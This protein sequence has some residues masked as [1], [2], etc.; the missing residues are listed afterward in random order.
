MANQQTI[1]IVLKATDN[2]SK[3]LKKFEAQA[4]A[5]SKRIDRL[6]ATV[7]LDVVANTAAAAAKVEKFKASV[8]G[9]EATISVDAN[10]SPAERA[11]LRLRKEIDRTAGSGNNLGAILGVV[12]WPAIISGA[13]LAAQ[14]VAALGAASVALTS[15][16][17][18]A[19]GV[20]AALPG[21][22]AAV[23]QG[24]GV[25][26]LAFSDG[27]IG[28]THEADR[29]KTQ[30]DAFQPVL[31]GLQQTAQRG[32]LP[33]VSDAFDRLLTLLPIA[34]TAIGATGSAMGDLARRAADLVTSGPFAADF[35]T[36]A[37]NNV[38]LI[39]RAGDGALSLANALRN[40]LVVGQP[41]LAWLVDLGARGAAW[42]DVATTAGRESGRL[43]GFL[44]RTQA[45]LTTLG[46]SV[47]DFTTGLFNIGGAANEM[48][49]KFLAAIERAAARFREWTGSVEGQNSLRD[50]FQRAEP[51]IAEVTRLIGDVAR[52]FGGLAGNSDLAPLIAQIREQFLPM[53]VKLA[54]T[55]T[56]SLGPALVNMAT[57]FGNLFTIMGTESGT[58]VG[59]INNFAALAG[60]LARFL[61]EH[62]RLA[63]II[64]QFAVLST[65]LKY[66]PFA[67]T[68]ASML[69]FGIAN[70]STGASVVAWFA[71]M[72]ASA[73][74]GIA[75]VA[76]SM[77]RGVAAGASAT[78]SLIAQAASA[79]ASMVASAARQVAAWALLAAQSMIH[80]VRTA[81]AFVVA[82]GPV[83][84]V[85]A[86]VVALAALIIA[87]WDKISAATK[88]IWE[89]TFAW[90][91]GV[92]QRINAAVSSAV[93]GV[94][95][96]VEFVM[97]VIKAVWQNAWQNVLDAYNNIKARIA[98]GVDS[99]F[100]GLQGAFTRGVEAIKS[101][102]ERIKEIAASPVRFIVD[103]VYNN[104]IRKFW[105]TAADVLSLSKLPEVRLGFASGGR[106][107]GG[108]DRTGRDDVLARLTRG[109]WVMPTAAVEKYGPG[110]M[111]AIQNRR[112]DGYAVGG[113][114]GGL[115]SGLMSRL[116]AWSAA[117]GSNMS[118]TSGL[119]TRSEQVVLYNR[120]LSGNGPVAARPGTSRHESG[121]A[122]DLA[123]IFRRGYSAG[124]RAAEFG[125]RYTVP[126][127]NW[128]VEA[129]GGAQTGGAA[130]AANNG[131]GGIMGWFRDRIAGWVSTI[132]E[133]V[134]RLVQ[135]YMLEGGAM[136]QLVGGA[137]L[138]ALEGAANVV[139][140]RGD[141]R[142]NGMA[143]GG[144]VKHRRGGTSVR[145]G[146]G[147]YDEAVVPLTGRGGSSGELERLV[148]LMAEQ[149][150]ELKRVRRATEEKQVLAVSGRAIGQTADRRLGAMGRRS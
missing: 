1:D 58:L 63:A 73:A 100:S 118:V 88:R 120:Y 30:I 124:A 129:Q 33:G 122:A 47:R 28:A 78:A 68:I 2:A 39:S 127:E 97:N 8:D 51:V 87:N 136:R 114:V 31:K 40:V 77:A 67:G 85:I 24:A 92:W 149:N 108:T 57:Q 50:F 113:D 59:V 130:V 94:R 115:N 49:N 89:A 126:S 4:A 56:G 16:V 146:E 60:V 137:G 132:L 46:H 112:F 37:T 26:A 148:A 3:V 44:Q 69:K 125:L 145:L 27:W 101:T 20:L 105:N 11:L 84:W 134:K 9:D 7:N 82:M 14:G 139:R 117:V 17:A 135:N 144:V 104:G 119:R 48:G 107:P 18:P 93:D 22:Y 62:P 128:H 43:A 41:L 70:A 23:G 21:L 45:V 79:A 103:S 133:P 64:V 81:A 110:F 96:R 10:T 71:K 38:G 106:V 111:N 140:G 102:W 91:Q 80:A 142:D 121:N 35:A 54:Q 141:D 86:A 65:T 52:A 98:S 150:Q 72:G 55:A 32:L 15:A 95:A 19:A 116:N 109:E 61:N 66:L 36:V 99:L 5:I 53:F 123:G 131:G 147:R 76:S 138:K 29:F 12:R 42:V 25:A 74:S 75:S 90:L 143:H 13:T 83:G 6:S 34:K